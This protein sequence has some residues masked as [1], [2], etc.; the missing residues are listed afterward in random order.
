MLFILL[1]YVLKSKR[2]SHTP[3]ANPLIAYGYNHDHCLTLNG[4]RLFSPLHCSG[5]PVLPQDREGAT[6]RCLFKVPILALL[7]NSSGLWKRW[8]ENRWQKEMSCSPLTRV[9]ILRGLLKKQSFSH[10]HKLGL[11]AKL[12]ICPDWS[13]ANHLKKCCFRSMLYCIYPKRCIKHSY[14]CQPVRDLRSSIGTGLDGT[15]GWW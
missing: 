2:V 11:T 12:Y 14:Q 3:E 9:W 8:V 6:S 1:V 10:Y 5:P 4:K 13:W 15:T 7:L